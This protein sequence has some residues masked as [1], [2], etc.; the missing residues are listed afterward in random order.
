MV[1]FVAILRRVL[2]DSIVRGAPAAVA[3]AV[4]AVEAAVAAAAGSTSA[5]LE[6]EPGK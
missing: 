3:V 1:F 2:S 5:A 6:A 4:A